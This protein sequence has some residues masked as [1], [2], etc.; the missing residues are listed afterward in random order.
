MRCV[1]S[2]G[3]ASGWL[4]DAV[5]VP[6]N[7]SFVVQ[8]PDKVSLTSLGSQYAAWSS[9]VAS[10]LEALRS[11][12]LHSMTDLSS[13]AL[14]EVMVRLQNNEQCVGKPIFTSMA[15]VHSDLYWQL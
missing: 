4:I 1:E 9:V 12:P 3:L 2:T 8:L 5:D 15:N 13:V 7:K 14:E 11:H 10:T 6:K